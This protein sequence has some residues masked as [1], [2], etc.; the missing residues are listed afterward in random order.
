MLPSPTTSH[1]LVAFPNEQTLYFPIKLLVRTQTVETTALF[2]S[3]ATRNFIDLR[4]LSLANFPLKKIPQPIGAFNMDGTPNQWGT[5]LWKALTCIVLPHS[6]DDLDLMVVSLGWKQVILGMPWLKF[7]NPHIDWRSNNLSFPRSLTL[8]NDDNSTSQRYLLQ[9]L[10]LD[11]DMKLSSL[12]SQQ[13]SSEDDASLREYLPQT[14]LYCEHLNKIALS[15]ELA[16]AAKTPDQKIPDWC[17]NLADIFSEKI[18][19]ILPPH[20]S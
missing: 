11:S 18:H 15:T 3:S 7:R 17:S 1:V 9:W 13:Y 20:W 8:N 10:G 14:D 12:L 19:N 2:D 16:Q 6:S 4:L 5:I